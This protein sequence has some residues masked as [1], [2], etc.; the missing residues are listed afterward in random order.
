MSPAQ[1]RVCFWT[2]ILLGLVLSTSGCWWYWRGGADY[3]LLASVPAVLGS[4][5]GLVASLGEERRLRS[6]LKGMVRSISIAILLSVA[7]AH[8][9][10][11]QLRELGLIPRMKWGK[12][13]AASLDRY[14]KEFGRY[15]DSL[16]QLGSCKGAG[17]P[18]LKGGGVY[19]Y[20]CD[21][22]NSYEL[23]LYQGFV[24]AYVLT[25]KDQ[26]WAHYVCW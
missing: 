13:V 23:W 5:L 26:E 10:G 4:F 3:V 1:G 8:G 6:Q 24:E 2:A 9:V 12:E 21:N 15:P 25:G 20:Q 17:V 22:G 7:L 14:F 16:A 18:T 11:L 19:D